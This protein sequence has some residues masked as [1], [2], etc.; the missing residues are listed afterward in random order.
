MRN[1][2][3]GGKH[4]ERKKKKEKKNSW[5]REIRNSNSSIGE[6]SDNES[7][8]TTQKNIHP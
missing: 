4:R 1:T 8:N 6:I 7:N 3:Q 5:L 2:S